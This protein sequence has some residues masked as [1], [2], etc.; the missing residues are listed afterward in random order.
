MPHDLLATYAA[1]ALPV[2]A[3]L[4]LHHTLAR[5]SMPPGDAELLAIGAGVRT[6]HLERTR[7]T[8]FHDADRP[9]RGPFRFIGHLT[10]N[11]ELERLTA[12]LALGADSVDT[13]TLFE[14]AARR[15]LCGVPGPTRSE[16]NLWKR[17][18]NAGGRPGIL[19]R[20]SRHLEEGDGT[21]A[22]VWEH[23]EVPD[24]LRTLAP[25]ARRHEAPVSVE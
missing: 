14:Y 23:V 21:T 20:V 13:A 2:G 15:A 7:V 6:A 5:S 9:S 19:A 1:H 18:V 24:D 17:Y 25:A 8:T 16:R 10:W 3:R 4:R 11:P 22:V 12:W